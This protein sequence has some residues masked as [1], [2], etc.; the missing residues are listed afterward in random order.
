[1]STQAQQQGLDITTLPVQQLSQLQQ[2][3]SQE[4]EHLSDSHARL[5][6]A[7]ARFRDCIRSIKDGVEGKNED[8]PLL[9]PLTTSLYVP[10]HPTSTKSDTVLVDVGTGYYVEKKTP[11]AIKF[12]NGKV[13]DLTKNLGD[14]E[15]AVG[16]KN[17]DLRM[18]E[19]V[20]RGKVLSEQ[21]EQKGQGGGGGKEG[22]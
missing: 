6:A 3:L 15:R 7:Q 21:A 4:L 19:D 20:L 22:D 14:I 8:T 18:V 9:I 12:Y 16:V 5:R 1:M 10:A 2:R 11:D 17:Q 13:D